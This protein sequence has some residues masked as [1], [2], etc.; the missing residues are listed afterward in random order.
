MPLEFTPALHDRR[1]LHAEQGSEI[2]INAGALMAG[3]VAARQSAEF[4][5]EAARDAMPAC[6]DLAEEIA[7]ECELRAMGRKP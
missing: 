4:G 7:R 2:Q 6:I 1:R 5:L 3:I